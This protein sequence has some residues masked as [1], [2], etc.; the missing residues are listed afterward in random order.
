MTKIVLIFLNCLLLFSYNDF[1][2]DGNSSAY[3]RLEHIVNTNENKIYLTIGAKEAGGLDLVKVDASGANILITRIRNVTTDFIISK[4][5]ALKDTNNN[6]NGEFILAGE[7]GGDSRLEHFR[8]STAAGYALILGH[9]YPLIHS[10]YDIVQE[11]NGKN[12]YFVSNKDDILN[13]DLTVAD[14]GDV[15][16]I[17]KHIYERYLNIT[18]GPT[19]AQSY[20]AEVDQDNIANVIREFSYNLDGAVD[21]NI[22]VATTDTFFT[23]G[24]HSADKETDQEDITI[25]GSTPI[26]NAGSKFA[27]LSVNASRVITTEP[28]LVFPVLTPPDYET[29]E[30]QPKDTPVTP[31]STAIY[32]VEYNAANLTEVIGPAFNRVYSLADATSHTLER[33]GNISKLVQ[34][35]YNVSL[36]APYNQVINWLDVNCTKQAVPEKYMIPWTEAEISALAGTLVNQRGK[37]DYELCRTNDKFIYQVIDNNLSRINRQWQF[38]YDDEAPILW[39][40]DIPN[41]NIQG[42]PP[43]GRIETITTD[44]TSIATISQINATVGGI[45]LFRIE[46]STPGT[47]ADRIK[48]HKT[49]RAATNTG[50][51]KSK[52]IINSPNLLKTIANDFLITG[53][54]ED[55]TRTDVRKTDCMVIKFDKNGNEL[56]TK[57]LGGFHDDNC[58]SVALDKNNTSPFYNDYVVVGNSGTRNEDD[59]NDSSSYGVKF[60]DEGTLIHVADGWS[61]ITNGTDRNITAQGKKEESN[62]M[63][64][65]HLGAYKSYFQFTKNQWLINQYPI[66]PL[67]GFWIF[68]IDGRHDIFLEGNLL[69]QKFSS[70]ELGWALLGTGVQLIN[71][72]Q[73][74]NLTALWKFKDQRWIENPVEI[75]PGE[76]FWA[77]KKQ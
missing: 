54:S 75:N 13:H 32:G 25:I 44:N 53:Q 10:I 1:I 45:N 70:S 31:G 49:Y 34:G 59:N 63:G 29:L 26:D 67:N 2:S 6:Y 62:T 61:L 18:P 27:L 73:K 35:Y 3:T 72:K 60:R 46:D 22:A 36:G 4:L 51:N 52:V 39:R 24:F 14:N 68:T 76:G 30:D 8:Y 9:T 48:W 20:L 55:I 43:G 74:F 57:S 56:W 66:E 71:A 5:L 47:I 11:K 33:V 7:I 77:K 15:L 69:E 21:V 17:G 40:Q 37:T 38:I 50:D 41:T 42:N 12:L 64:V 23:L 16:E 28:L 58:Y 19:L 65:I